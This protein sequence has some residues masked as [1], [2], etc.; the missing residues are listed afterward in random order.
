MTQEE[1]MAVN[2]LRATGLGYKAIASKLLISQNTVKSYL[3]KHDTEIDKSKSK[4][5]NISLCL[6]CG[7]KLIMTP[8]KKKRKF[9]SDK[10]RLSYWNSHRELI[11]H[12]NT[13]LCRG[14]GKEFTSSSKNRLYCSHACYITKRF[15]K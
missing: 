4:S 9:C 1:K 12:R 15:S 2:A 14:C 5:N 11:K 10:C 13:L 7:K 6:N 3:R 8:H